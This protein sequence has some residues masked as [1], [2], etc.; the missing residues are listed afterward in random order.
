MAYTEEKLSK[1]DRAKIGV[2]TEKLD[3]EGKNWFCHNFNIGRLSEY[4]NCFVDTAVYPICWS[5]LLQ[6]AKT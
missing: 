1:F 3:F 5:K 2:K 4:E 6:E